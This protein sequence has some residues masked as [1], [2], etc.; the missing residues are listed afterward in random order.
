M[1]VIAGTE[2]GTNERHERPNDALVQ[3]I[4][5]RIFSFSREPRG[6]SSAVRKI[7]PLLSYETEGIAWDSERDRRNRIMFAK[8]GNV[9]RAYDAKMRR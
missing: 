1:N 9:F 6:Y 7:A 3:T 8:T 5:N 2:Q 4:V